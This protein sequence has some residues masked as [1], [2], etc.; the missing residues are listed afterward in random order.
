MDMVGQFSNI[1]SATAATAIQNLTIDDDDT[2]PT[3]A[4]GQCLVI[5][6]GGMMQGGGMGGGRRGGGMGSGMMQGG[7]QMEGGMDHDM[8]QGDQDDSSQQKESQ[9]EHQDH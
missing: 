6:G 3:C 5:L 8:M 4:L 7:G 9:G 1:P 2:A